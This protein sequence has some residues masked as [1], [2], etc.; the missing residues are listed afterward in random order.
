MGTVSVDGLV[1]LKALE[2]S[3][4]TKQRVG[5]MSSHN[6]QSVLY[7]FN[8]AV[9]IIHAW[10]CCDAAAQADPSSLLQPT[11]LAARHRRKRLELVSVQL[12]QLFS[13]AW[14]REW[15]HALVGCAHGASCSSVSELREGRKA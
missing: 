8:R 7:L 9:A 6:R 4:A 12:L 5:G 2:E 15:C 13:L 11:P 3:H 1:D 14:R 10:L